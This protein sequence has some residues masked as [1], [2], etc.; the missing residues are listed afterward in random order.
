M[1]ISTSPRLLN[2]FIHAIYQKS[3]AQ[4]CSGSAPAPGAV[5][6]AL[7]ENPLAT[8]PLNRLCPHPHA[9]RPCLRN[10]FIR[11]HP[12]PSVVKNPL[13]PASLPPISSIRWWIFFVFVHSVC[14]VFISALCFLFSAFPPPSFYV[15]Q[16]HYTF[17]LSCLNRYMRSVSR[18]LEMA[19][20]DLRVKKSASMPFR[21]DRA[22]NPARRGPRPAKLLENVVFTKRTRHSLDFIGDR[23]KTNPNQTPIMMRINAL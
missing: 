7:A 3:A 20:C 15:S 5:F 16:Q 11:V 1:A 2:S 21:R 9:P 17:A 14:L 8:E 22:N 10:I 4:K 6:R 19:I 18:K 23:K 12:C 13:F